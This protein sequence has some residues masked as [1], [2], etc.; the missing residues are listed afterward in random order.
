MYM[1]MRKD[2]KSQFKFTTGALMAQ[3]AHG[4]AKA[5]HVFRDRLD[6]EAY[7]DDIDHMHKVTLRVATGSELTDTAERL[8]AA[9]VPYV[10]WVENPERIETCL[11]TAPGRKSVIGS[12]LRHLSLFTN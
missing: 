2:L 9:G 6:T 7:L 5:L 10:I 12:H 4:T 11:V 1:V 3:A 8:D